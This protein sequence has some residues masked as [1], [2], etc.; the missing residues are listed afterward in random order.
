MISCQ[1]KATPIYILVDHLKY[2]TSYKETDN[3][4]AA[5]INLETL[6]ENHDKEKD[7]N[8]KEGNIKFFYKRYGKKRGNLLCKEKSE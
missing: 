1:Y 3:Q 6:R 8:W 2:W 7:K 5:T 4:E